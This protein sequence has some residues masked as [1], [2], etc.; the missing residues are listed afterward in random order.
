MRKFTTLIP[1]LWLACSLIALGSCQGKNKTAV[2][3][4]ANTDNKYTI[5]F[6]HNE[7]NLQDIYM[8]IG[9]EYTR[10][11]P[12]VTIEMISVPGSDYNVKIDTTILSG[13]QLDI[14][15]QNNTMGYSVRAIQGEYYPLDD[16]LAKENIK[17]FDVY[18]IDATVDDGKIYALPG[19]VKYFIV[20]LNKADLDRAGLPVP[21]FSWTW[22]DYREYAKKLTWGEGPNKHYGS[23]MFH[24]V[25]FDLLD[26]YNM[27]DGNPYVNRDFTHNINH[28][29]FR[30]SLE[31]RYALEQ[32][33]KTQIPLSE[34]L[35]MQL[36]YRSV[37]LSGR[38]S[39]AI[40][41][42]NIIPQI[43]QTDQVPHDFDTTFAPVPRPKNGGREG[44][45]YGDNRFYSIGATTGDAWETYKYLR[46]F[47]TEGIPMKNVTF[48]AEKNPKL[49][50][51]EMI[52]R[53]TA[54]APQL[55]DL[56]TLRRL[57]NWPELHINYWTHVPSFTSEIDAIY[58]AEADKAI[59]GEISIDRVFGNSLPQIETILDR[60]KAKVNK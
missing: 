53:M 16:L 29:S 11:N 28:P 19:D 60:E 9:E 51:D 33:D 38:A 13:E 34:V 58:R 47:T 55:Y 32:V 22:D 20:W 31:F 15:V 37:F 43:T 24:W 18:S 14:S 44:Y 21:D 56:P 8:G 12:N 39:M 52:D 2:E 7:A 25:H 57:M 17:F 6:F 3:T 26:V 48:T 27:V 45:V 36:D 54:G 1:A 41:L 59:M 5:K 30:S 35:A 46:Y 40:A 50:V 42:T 49:S 4:T 10:R 23:M